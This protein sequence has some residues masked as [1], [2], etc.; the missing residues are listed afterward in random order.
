MC[1]Y[2][3]EIQVQR[4]NRETAL[5]ERWRFFTLLEDTCY[6]RGD[7]NE[8]PSPPASAALPDPN[9]PL[10][11]QK[12]K[13]TSGKRGQA[14]HPTPLPSEMFIRKKNV[15]IY[16]TP[17]GFFNNVLDFGHG[18]LLRLTEGRNKSGLVY[19]RWLHSTTA[20][21]SAAFLLFR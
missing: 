21:H 1:C 16:I 8:R 13:Q 7:P 18:A 19:C 4:R 12:F 11:M 15:C 9:N 17:A 5:D 6:L 20:S 14:T 10:V 3:N 2:F